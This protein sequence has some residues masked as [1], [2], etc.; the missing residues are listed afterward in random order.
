MAVMC[1][2]VLFLAVVMAGTETTETPGCLHNGVYRREGESFDD[3][4]CNDCWCSPWGV[5]C[6]SVLCATPQCHDSVF[7]AGD[8]CPSC[9]SGPNC[10]L[11][12]GRIISVGVNVT[13]NGRVCRCDTPRTYFGILGVICTR[14]DQ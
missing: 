7:K 12:G 10:R 1:L 13:M 14:G 4:D 8:C 5:N 9:P 11:P 2:L 6:F 3:G